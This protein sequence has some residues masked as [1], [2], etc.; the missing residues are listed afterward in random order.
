MPQKRTKTTTEG[1]TKTTARAKAP[2][3]RRRAPDLA[4]LVRDPEKLLAALEA[5]EARL[6]EESSPPEAEPPPASGERPREPEL[7]AEPARKNVCPLLR[8]N[9]TAQRTWSGVVVIRR[10]PAA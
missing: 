5:G 3:A 1:A 9:E 7:L 2:R 6:H 10:R 8:E 4:A